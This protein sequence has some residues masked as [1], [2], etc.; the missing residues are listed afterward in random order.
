MG[1]RRTDKAD[2]G[3]GV[4]RLQAHGAVWRYPAHILTL[5]AVQHTKGML[6]MGAKASF[7]ANSALRMERDSMRAAVCASACTILRRKKEGDTCAMCS[8][9]VL[10]KR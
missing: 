8:F 5:H 1:E 6:S 2:A 7:V 9:H 3:A 4:V 10:M